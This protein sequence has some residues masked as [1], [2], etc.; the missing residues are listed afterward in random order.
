MSQ[1]PYWLAEALA[2]ERSPPRPALQGRQR[3]D[4]CIVGGGFTGLWTA[5]MCKQA[6]PDWQVVVLEKARCGSG[7]SGRNGGCMLTWSTK[8]PS[9]RRWFGD[10]EASRLVQASEQ[11][12]AD[13]ASFCQQHAIDA[14]I[15]L[16]GA[17]YAASNPAQ[18]G[19]LAPVLSMLQ[20]HGLNSWTALSPAQTRALS[21]SALL[22][23]GYHS[24]PAG[25]L[26]PGKLV[27]GL[28]RVASEMG[29]QVHEHS[30]MTHLQED[31]QVIL[32]TAQGQVEASQAVLALNA[33]MPG[34]FPAFA[35]S[36]LLVSSDMIITD[37]RPGEIS[38]LGLERGQAV[39]DLRTFVHYWRS[40]PDGRLMLGK[41]GNH[42]AFGNRMQ[43]CF[44]QP[45]RHAAALQLTMGRL[46]P[47]LATAPVV[48]SWTGA[49]DRSATGFPFFG[50]LPG[51][52]RVLYGLGYSGNGVVQSHLGGRILSS[53]LLGERN[54]WTDSGLVR[55]PLAHFPPEPLRWCGAMLVR[56]AI[57]RVEQAED[58]QHKPR[59]LDTRLAACAGMAGKT[60]HARPDATHG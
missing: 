35:N 29:V 60:D 1:L 45:S 10:S 8:Y 49:S 50:R 56:N 58:R 57:R 7:A 25:S 23:D 38:T 33:D 53:L 37:A 14:D 55:G 40:T 47:S 31:G 46:F 34:Q 4:V 41:G 59:W 51:H 21:G 52:Q 22:Q 12:V 11:A 43:A 26:Q 24:A 42:I 6:R 54:A 2:A 32:H 28:L 5:I 36:I 30:A 16:G 20:E 3:A 39:C 44:D 9:L 27:R 15:R 48:Q 19:R 17:V 13:I 18:I